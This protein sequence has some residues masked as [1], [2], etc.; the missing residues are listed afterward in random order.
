MFAKLLKHEWRATRG[1]I[2]LLCIII[3]ISG[4]AFGGTVHYMMRTEIRQAEN[5]SVAE[6][7]F[8]LIVEDEEDEKTAISDRTLVLCILI[9][10]LSVIAIAVCCAG[11]L[12]SLICRFYKRCFTDEGYLTFTLPVS[13]HQI[14]LSSISNCIL[15]SLLV[16]LAVLA[17]AVL[18]V[19]LVLAAFP[20]DIDWSLLWANG[21]DVWQQLVDSLTG[22]LDQFL[23]VGFSSITGALSELLLLMLAVTV[24]ALIAR[25]HKVLTAVCVYFCIT[26]VR[27]A[28]Y[29]W[30]MISAA[31]T[32][33]GH[34]LL[35]AHG[36]LSV[37]ITVAA[38]LL[39]HR[40]TGKKLNLT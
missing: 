40:L 8:Y 13:D 20:A 27:S 3:L 1:V 4:L 26:S 35:G 34:L 36:A 32:Q 23:L 21:Q 33:N 24:G 18:M 37:L 15:G 31:A 5:V 29:S 11:S 19:A 6:D 30:M 17:A 28:I 9:L 22:N 16:L 38:Y 7:G 2:A 10:T 25:K 12:Y 39:M 14:L